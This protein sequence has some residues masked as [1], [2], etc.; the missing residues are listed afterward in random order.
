MITSIVFD[1]QLEINFNILAAFQPHTATLM[2][3]QLATDMYR[4]YTYY[5]M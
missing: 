1:D 5:N 2:A 3:T 4:L